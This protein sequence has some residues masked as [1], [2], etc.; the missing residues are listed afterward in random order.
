MPEFSLGN[1]EMKE[2]LA[3]LCEDFHELMSFMGSVKRKWQKVRD[4]KL[5]TMICIGLVLPMESL[6][7]PQDPRLLPGNHPMCRKVRLD[8]Q[9][10]AKK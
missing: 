10:C 4:M 7:T 2:R 9:A 8:F 1:E 6:Q 5:V 3:A